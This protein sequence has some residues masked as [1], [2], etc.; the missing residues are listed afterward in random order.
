MIFLAALK[1]MLAVCYDAYGTK[2]SVENKGIWDV[3]KNVIYCRQAILREQTVH[4]W[5]S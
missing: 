3:S 4:L 1:R 2:N 5:T